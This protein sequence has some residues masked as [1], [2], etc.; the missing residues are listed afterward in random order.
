MK[1]EIYFSV[2]VFVFSTNAEMPKANWWMFEKIEKR[3]CLQKYKLQTKIFSRQKEWISSELNQIE[4]IILVSL[5]RKGLCMWT[6]SCCPRP[7]LLKCVIAC[8]GL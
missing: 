6:F 4:D 8:F 7:S 1:E 3:I 2:L 5:I